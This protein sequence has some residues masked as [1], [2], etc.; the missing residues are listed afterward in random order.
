MLERKVDREGLTSDTRHHPG[1]RRN[2]SR[3]ETFIDSSDEVVTRGTIH[4]VEVQ[5]GKT[6][7]A[8]DSLVVVEGTLDPTS[9]KAT[10]DA[11][12]TKTSE[13]NHGKPIAYNE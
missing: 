8:S 1:I 6:I 9:L 11:C 4:A 3:K 12:G 5:T 10:G 2:R 13:S 7:P